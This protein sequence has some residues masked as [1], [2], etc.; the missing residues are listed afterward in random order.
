MKT[1]DEKKY[2]HIELNNEVT[3]RK[4]N[5]FFNLEK[6]QEALKVYLEEIHDKTIYFDSEIERL[7]YLVDNNFYF[8]VFEKYNEA[9]LIEITEY[10][11]S[12][13][14]QFASYMSA[15]KFYKDY[16]LKTND[17]QQ[18]LEDYN[19]HVAIVSMYLANGDK[20]QAKQ[21][22]SSM[23]EQRYQP[24]TPTFLNAGRARRGELVSCFLLEVDDSLN[25]INFIDSTAKQLSKIG[26]GVAINLSKLRAR[27]EAIKGIKGVA[28]GVLPV[29]KSL[30]GG[31]SYADQLGQRPG[32]GAVYLNI[33]HYDV[34]EFLDTKKVNADEDLRLSTIS[35][36]LIVPS[37]F[38]DLAKEGKDFY[39]FAPHTVKQE[40]GVTLDDIDLDK[41]YDDMVA[42]PNVEKKKKDAR[43]MLNTIAQ[44]QLQS[45]YPYLM[46]KD[47]ANKVH[48][49]SNIGQIKMSNLC[50]EIFQLQETSVI[51]DYGTEDDIKRDISCNLGSLNIVNVMESGKFRDSVHTGM[52]ALTVVSDEANIQ[53]APGVKKANSELHSVG[54][55][56]MN[57]HGYLAKNKIGYE[58][59]EAK[60]FANIFF[61]MMNYY[62]IERSMQ[63][64]K[65]RGEKYLDFEKSDYANG[66]Y[67]EFYTSQEF[68]PQFEKVRELFE[69]LDIPTAED[70]KA[71]QKDVEQYG[72]YHA[73]RLAIAP[74]Q[75]ISY[76]QNATSSVMPIVDQIER[77][78]YGNAET[79]YPMPFLSPET[80]W[81][82]KSAFNTDQMKLIDLVSTIQTHVDQGISTILYVN[83]EI[84]TRELSRLYVYAHHKGLKSLYYT[85]NKL[86]SV[87]ECTSCAI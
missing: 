43:E 74:T 67:F 22:I 59:E 73:Y 30:E 32:A 87:E 72:L 18:F 20:N 15:S 63:I 41:Y 10:A 4:D 36:G 83:S 52:D 49:N 85:R 31:F 33:F 69:G 53:N 50:T 79:F 70:W 51:N 29:A 61:M 38:F 23:V 39:M 86:L 13:N 57:L 8:N 47:N 48:A 6:D 7:H 54:L 71:L 12:I 44:T 17:K 14:F 21:F 37:K 24:A 60:D 77:R 11:K 78:T 16:A 27:G 2:N 26:G 56:V 35:T 19:Q 80:M 66:K 81:Y 28:K 65:E 68:E 84:S 3:K 9:D 58:S 45:G 64:A 75:S 42:N 25:S 5:G 82:Y 55:G 1:M 40:Y 34:E 62:S 46:F 76:V